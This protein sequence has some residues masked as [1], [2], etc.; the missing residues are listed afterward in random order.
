MV[1]AT[2]AVMAATVVMAED[3]ATAVTAIVAGNQ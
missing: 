1:A 3:T 2:T